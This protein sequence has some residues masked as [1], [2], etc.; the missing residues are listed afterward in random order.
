MAVEHLSGLNEELIACAGLRNNRVRVV[1]EERGC[2]EAT[3]RKGVWTGS[4]VGRE[5]VLGRGRRCC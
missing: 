1:A 3:A 5:W 2:A 4:D